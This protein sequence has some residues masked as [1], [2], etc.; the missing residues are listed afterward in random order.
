VDKTGRILIERNQVMEEMRNYFQ[1]L[2]EENTIVTE[3]KDLTISDEIG[4]EIE[5]LTHIEV[6]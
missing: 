2:T 1:E 6:K 3:E 4:E 5:C